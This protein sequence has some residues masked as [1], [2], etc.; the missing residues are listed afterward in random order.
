MAL[1]PHQLGPTSQQRPQ[2]VDYWAKSTTWRAYIHRHRHPT[3]PATSPHTVTQ[4]PRACN[5]NPT[6]AFN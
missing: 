2:L 4:P 3:L 5:P 1:I 6:P